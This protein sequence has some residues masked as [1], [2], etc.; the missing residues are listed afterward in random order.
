MCQWTKKNDTN[1]DFVKENIQNA[2][3][4]LSAHGEDVFLEWQPK[5]VNSARRKLSF[6]P[7]HSCYDDCI[8]MQVDREGFLNF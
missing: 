8:M 4:E 3:Y 7:K 2:L 6:V 1:F 5:L